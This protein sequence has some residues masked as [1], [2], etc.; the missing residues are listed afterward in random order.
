VITVDPHK[1][2]IKTVPDKIDEI[3]THTD[4][5]VAEVFETLVGTYNSKRSNLLDVTNDKDLNKVL[6]KT[7]AFPVG[8][9][10]PLK[11]HELKA[12]QEKQIW[13]AVQEVN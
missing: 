6:E 13:K 11:L 12:Q 4:K 3:F 5:K 7:I 10:E 9:R 2:H 8:Y 1:E